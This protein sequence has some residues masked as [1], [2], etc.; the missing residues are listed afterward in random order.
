M[1]IYLYVKTHNETGLKYLGKTSNNPF[2]Y[3][4]SGVDWKLHLKEYGNDHT[5]V[6]IKECQSNSELS[7]WGRY[8]SE[9]WDVANSSEWANRIPETGGGSTPS[10]QT[11]EKLRQSQLGK[12]KPPR[13][14]EHIEKLSAATKGI[15]RPRSKEHQ[16][17]WT[18]SSTANWATNTERKMQVSKLGKSNKGRKHSPES[19]EKKRQAMLRYWESKR[20]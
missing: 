4:G 19:A 5:T 16:T 8:Y 9:L 2:S 18:E 12:K 10:D 7:E 15:V 20:V 11:R 14:K 6:V 3:N 17:A 13:T 1:T